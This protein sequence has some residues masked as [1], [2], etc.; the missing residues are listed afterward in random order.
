MTDTTEGRSANDTGASGWITA[1]LSPG[2]H[3][4]GKPLTD[5]EGGIELFDGSILAGSQRGLAQL[6]H[7]LAQRFGTHDTATA[8][9]GAVA[10]RDESAAKLRRSLTYRDLL[11]EITEQLRYVPAEHTAEALD[12]PVQIDLM[13]DH[14]TLAHIAV[15]EGYAAEAD[16]DPAETQPWRLRLTPWLV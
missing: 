5:Q 1:W 11:I 12:T 3:Y 8:T 6:G 15:E 14:T 13:G 4:R 7:A 16:E 9:I 10:A 2:D